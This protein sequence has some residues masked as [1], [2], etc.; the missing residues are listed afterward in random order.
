M[1]RRGK[2][3]WNK[4]IKGLQSWHNITGLKR[5]GFKLSE[6]HKRKIGKANKISL[7][8]HHLPKSVRDKISKNN[9][10]KKLSLEAR[11]KISI[12]HRG[13]NNHFWQGG[14]SE[15][16]DIIRHSLEY[17]EWRRAVYKRDN[18]TCQ[19]C[20]LG[21]YGNLN[22]DHIKAFSKYPELRFAIDNGRTLCHNCHKKTDNYGKRALNYL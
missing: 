10:G 11:Q 18:Y 21:G 6:E 17:K 5:K 8:G 4:G 9:M 12:S 20:G 16:N 2:T 14:I 19:I 1:S 15:L 7:K 22:A 13:R 3:T